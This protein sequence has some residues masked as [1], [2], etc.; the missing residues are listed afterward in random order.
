M[1]M[2]SEIW[3]LEWERWEQRQFM[4]AKTW[5]QTEHWMN[6]WETNGIDL[7][8]R[9]LKYGKFGMGKMEF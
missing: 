2:I 3:I 1:G 5:K 9:H 8:I 4:M 7:G 6:K